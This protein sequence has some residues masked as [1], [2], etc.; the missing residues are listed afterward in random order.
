MG[1]R[2]WSEHRGAFQCGLPRRGALVFRDVHACEPLRDLVT[3]SRVN[4]AAVAQRPERLVVDQE[5]GVFDSLR[6]YQLPFDCRAARQASCRGSRRRWFGTGNARWTLL[7]EIARGKPPKPIPFCAPTSHRRADAARCCELESRRYGGL[8]GPSH[9]RTMACPIVFRHRAPDGRARR[10]IR[11]E[12][13]RHFFSLLPDRW[14]FLP[15][16]PA[17]IP[18]ARRGHAG[19]NGIDIYYTVYGEGPPVLSCMARSPIPTIGA[20]R[21]RPSRSA[22]RSS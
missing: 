4:D 20:I 7:S 21:F 12:L 17:P 8:C 5:G 6:L 3:L 11:R 19:V 13:M 14:K 1:I 2:H 22:T 10:G 15:P 9:S 18:S 16:T